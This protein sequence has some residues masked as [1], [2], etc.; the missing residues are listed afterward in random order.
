[1]QRP[2]LP[3]AEHST[4]SHPTRKTRGTAR[5]DHYLGTLRPQPPPAQRTK[6]DPF[7][8]REDRTHNQKTRI[9]TRANQAATSAGKLPATAAVATANS[10]A[11]KRGHHAPRRGHS[12]AHQTRKR[13]LPPT[14]QCAHK[15][16]CQLHTKHIRRIRFCAFI[17]FIFLPLHMTSPSRAGERAGRQCGTEQQ[18]AGRPTAHPVAAPYQPQPHRVH[19]RRRRLT[20]R[21]RC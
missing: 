15:K 20:C 14:R 9:R 7:R 6:R 17:I 1:M 2:G 5:L 3:A 8:A 12:G 16:K 10:A 18:R 19:R 4:T 13:G 21:A 11:A